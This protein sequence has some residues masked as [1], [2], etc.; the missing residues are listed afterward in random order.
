MVYLG[1]NEMNWL[2]PE[3]DYPLP[4][5]QCHMFYMYLAGPEPAILDWYGHCGRSNVN[6]VGGSGGM[7]HQDKF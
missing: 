1:V 4:C 5:D 7:L 3:A 2:P 6:K